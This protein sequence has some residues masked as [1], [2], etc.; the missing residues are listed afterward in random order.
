MI[1]GYDI[2]A[3]GEVSPQTA[4]LVLRLVRETW[5][6][7]VAL[8]ENDTTSIPIEEATRKVWDFPCGFFV[9]ENQ[10]AKLSWDEHGKTDE[11]D[12]QMVYVILSPE[13]LD[14]VASGPG[15]VT[16]LLVAEI[17]KALQANKWS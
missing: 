4:N 10:Q 17:I 3:K 9:F 14:F 2:E 8:P 15:T 7:A 6:S 5:P 1:G 11:N 13:G 12:D 16:D